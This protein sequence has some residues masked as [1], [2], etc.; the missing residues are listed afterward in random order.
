MR[1]SNKMM[2]EQAI[3]MKGTSFTLSVIHL[4]NDE[5]LTNLADFIASKVNQ[6]PDFFN[7][8]PLVINI[9]NIIGDID[10]NQLEEAVTQ[11]GMN[12]V[13][14]DG[15]HSAEQKQTVRNAGIS[16]ISNTFQTS[17]AAVA[18]EIKT[19]IVEKNVTKT[20][21]HKGQIR[22]GQQIYAQDASLTVIGSVSAGAEVI[23]DGSIHVYGALRGRAIAGAKGD[24]T[25]QI[26][27]NRLDAE[28]LSIN[29]TY[30]LSDAL[31]EYNNVQA[32][33]HC[34]NDKLEIIKFD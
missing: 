14:I 30:V 9:S 19:V 18:P 24:N 1:L 31:E 16:V 32:H 6:A 34:L 25:A 28:L 17:K 8:A 12:L 3:K 13:G 7:A 26:F 4:E 21:V 2:T 5:A 10:F 15:C 29:G 20:I 11:N 23:A 22:S 33:V 27:C